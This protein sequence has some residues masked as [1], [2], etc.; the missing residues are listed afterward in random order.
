MILEWVTCLSLISFGLSFFSS[1]S[2]SKLLKLS[3]PLQELPR[4]LLKC[5]EDYKLGWFI[6]A[7]DSEAMD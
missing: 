5:F 3:E 4:A 1:S 2:E 7:Y 6:K